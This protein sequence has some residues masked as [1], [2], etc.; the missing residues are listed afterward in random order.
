MVNTIMNTTINPGGPG[1]PQPSAGKA[2]PVAAGDVGGGAAGSAAA[3]PAQAGDQVRLTESA[4]AIGAATRAAD[5]PVDTQRVEHI[6]QAIADG[7]YKVDSQR[8]ADR[9]IALEKQIR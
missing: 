3:A 4:R 5:A 8:I 2:K 7:T 1:V 6:K 9:L